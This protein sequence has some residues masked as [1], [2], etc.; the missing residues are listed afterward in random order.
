MDELTEDVDGT[1]AH[2]LRIAL[3]GGDV[4]LVVKDT[5]GDGTRAAT[6]VEVCPE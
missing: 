1:P 4:E 6:A 5:Q 2:K 3:K